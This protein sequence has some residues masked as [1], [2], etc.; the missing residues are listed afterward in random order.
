M[1]AVPLLKRS[2]RGPTATMGPTTRTAVL[3]LNDQ[4]APAVDLRAAPDRRGSG[5]GES[6]A[7]AQLSAVAASVPSASSVPSAREWFVRCFWPILK[8]WLDDHLPYSM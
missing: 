3:E 4:L 5:Q 6:S 8:Q 2:P 7:L 1:W